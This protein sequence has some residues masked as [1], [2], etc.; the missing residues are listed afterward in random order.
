[1]LSK[2]LFC[3]AYSE[4][5]SHG[6]VDVQ[7]QIPCPRTES[8]AERVKGYWSN[9]GE[10]RKT[11]SWK[12]N[13]SHVFFLPNWVCQRGLE[14]IRYRSSKHCSEREKLRARLGNGLN[15]EV[16]LPW[17][18]LDPGIAREPKMRK[19]RG[20][21]KLIF[22]GRQ[23]F[24]LKLLGLWPWIFAYVIGGLFSCLQSD[25]D[26]GYDDDGVSRGSCED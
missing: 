4:R 16:I 19:L 11:R 22:V 24:G 5:M 20:M 23:A 9:A 26:D 7:G 12:V 2:W 13:F 17:E 15:E 3:V 10:K 18:P 14:G 21:E 25:N 8:I 1:M 6:V